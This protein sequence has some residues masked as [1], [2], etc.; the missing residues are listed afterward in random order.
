MLLET[1]CARGIQS[2]TGNRAQIGFSHNGRLFSPF[3][4]TVEQLLAT[5]TEVEQVLHETDSSV[6]L[7]DTRPP[8]QYASQVIWTLM[9]AC[10]FLLSSC[11]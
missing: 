1:E 5:I 8:E 2:E 7:V 9:V 4:H 11:G 10:F 3:S 6:H